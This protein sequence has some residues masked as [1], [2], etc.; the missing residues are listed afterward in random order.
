MTLARLGKELD[1][2][3]GHARKNPN[4][5]WWAMVLLFPLV[6]FFLDK[7]LL[8]QALGILLAF[9]IVEYVSSTLDILEGGRGQKTLLSVGIYRDKLNDFPIF[10]IKVVSIFV[11]STWLQQIMS[12]YVSTNLSGIVTAYGVLGVMFLYYRRKVGRS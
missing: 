3:A 8:A 7:N 2:F 1:K 5:L 6:S 11:I 12:A 9:P 4:R 10:A